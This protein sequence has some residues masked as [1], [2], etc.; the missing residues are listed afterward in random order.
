MKKSVVVLLSLVLSMAFL[1]VGCSEK[2]GSGKG[3]VKKIVMADASWDSI[4]VHNRVVS[5]ILENGYGDYEV[6]Y[7]PGDTIPLFKGV[8]SGDIDI[9]MESWH[10]NYMDAYEEGIEEGKVFNIGPNMPE[11]PQGWYV[12]RYMIE[13]DPERGIEASAPDLKSIEDL[14]KYWEL[15]KDPENPDKGQILIGPPGWTATE[16]SDSYLQKYGL[17][18]F[19]TG[20]LPGSG[21][22]LAASMVSAFDAGEPWIGYYWEPTS[23]IGRLD[24]VMIPG[25]EFPPTSVDVLIGRRVNDEMPEL[26]AFLENYSTSLKQNNKMLAVMEDQGLDAQ[27]TAEW[28]L[29]EYEDQWTSW[30]D[31][32]VAEKVKAALGE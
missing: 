16:R 29:R 10:E 26:K 3:E 12:P 19:F 2:S 5:F 7:I 25:S 27:E 23:V 11:A 8:T 31:T 14:T 13:G 32:E 1:T 4:L 9:L 30:V 15:V 18:E 24:M 28:F 22:A 21:T 20:V 6:E 17:D